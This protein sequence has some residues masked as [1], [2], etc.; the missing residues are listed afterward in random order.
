[1][2]RKYTRHGVIA[3]DE[4]YIPMLELSR[5]HALKAVATGRA[6]I[7]D[8][9]TWAHHGLERLHHQ[10]AVHCVVYLG[11]QAV[12]EAR[13]LSGAGPKGVLRRDHHTCA[14][15]GSRASTVDH[16]I[17]RCQGGTTTWSNL[18]A[19]CLPCNQIKGGRTPEQAGMR[20][21]R[22][23]RSPRSLLLERFHQLAAGC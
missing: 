19:S 12:P 9:E 20:L 16:V 5:R 11:V 2:S 13:L 22:P 1:M 8:L 4:R 15:C 17:P 18:V 3:V 7:L 6:R 10:R 14:Y 23:A 21:L